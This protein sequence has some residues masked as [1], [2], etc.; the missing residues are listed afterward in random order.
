M[1]NLPVAVVI[2][3]DEDILHLLESVLIRAGFDVHT[4]VGGHEGIETVR[5]KR[6]AVVTVDV[7]LPDIDG[8]EVLRQIREFST[9][10]VV[11]LTG[12]AEESDLVT[13]FENGADDYILK[14]FR[15]REIRF[16]IAAMM[17]RPRNQDE[18]QLPATPME[19][20]TY[21]GRRDEGV[22]Q[23]NGLT[24]DVPNRTASLNGS[25]LELTRSELD[26]LHELLRGAGS[27]RTRSDLVRA[28]RGQYS[29]EE[30]IPESD[31]RALEAH[32]G[33]LRRKLGETANAPRLLHT[34][35][36]LGYRLTPEPEKP[37][38]N[39]R[40]GTPPWT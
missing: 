3:D 35:H 29:Q 16:K 1:S 7:G 20:T 27:I 40:R 17:R 4:A 10:Y 26:V 13:A 18:G 23:H 21:P 34:V 14:P 33:N 31:L 36:G 8:F 38:A 25:A 6:P 37:G 24:L 9:T 30:D 2:E 11:M 39:E 22:L 19:S 12:R 15:P 28:I 5:M 32:I